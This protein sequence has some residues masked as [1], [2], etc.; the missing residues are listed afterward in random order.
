MT[1]EEKLKLEKFGFRLSRGGGHSART[2]MVEELQLLFDYVDDPEASKQSYLDAIIVENCLGK[3]SQSGR[4]ITSEI[5]S[6]MYGFD[7]NIPIFRLLR[8]FW[9]KDIDGRALLAALCAYARDPIFRMSVPY[10][11]SLDKG[12]QVSRE[13]LEAF[14]EEQ[15]PGRYSTVTHASVSRNINASW[16]KTGHL[17]GRGIKIRTQAE[18]TV[19]STAYAAILALMMGHRG[20]ALFDSDIIRMLDVSV[21]RAMDF[22][23]QASEKGW[24][25]YKRIGDIVEVG[26]PSQFSISLNGGSL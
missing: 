3:S 12:V 10:I 13:V 11:L 25:V 17:S 18:P 4:R 22:A 7:P 16:T 23:Q 15:E 20:R 26:I 5:I 24:L 14:I 6:T 9:S 8:F 19:A 21:G 2:I 1:E